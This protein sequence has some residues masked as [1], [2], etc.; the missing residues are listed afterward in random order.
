M[1]CPCTR[2]T[3]PEK[4]QWHNTSLTCSKHGYYHCSICIT[5]FAGLIRRSRDEK[6]SRERE[7]ERE[8]EKEREREREHLHDYFTSAWARERERKRE[9]E[10]ESVCVCVCERGKYREEGKER[11]LN[12]WQARGRNS[13]ERTSFTLEKLKAGRPH[14][15][16]ANYLPAQ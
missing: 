7:R 13:R 1:F 8:R 15:A 14:G 9:R 3:C 16:Y 6:R 12:N 2:H 4:S 11:D 10:R 5:I